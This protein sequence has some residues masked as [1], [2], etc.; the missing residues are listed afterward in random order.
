MR[1]KERNPHLTDDL[2]PVPLC[3]GLC[4]WGT[5]NDDANRA[6]P[7]AMSVKSLPW[8]ARRSEKWF[9]SCNAA[10]N[11]RDEDA[12]ERV[13]ALTRAPAMLPLLYLFSVFLSAFA[14]IE[15]SSLRLSRTHNK[16]QHN[17]TGPV[18][19]T[20]PM[21]FEDPMACTHNVPDEVL[22]SRISVPSY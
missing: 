4:M 18:P 20:S 22:I 16:T 1:E 19:L 8:P 21:K 11:P 7:C 6:P 3:T 10:T 12:P 14:R 17:T 5:A 13:P 15:A 9:S 2:P